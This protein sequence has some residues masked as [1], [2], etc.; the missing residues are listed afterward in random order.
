MPADPDDLALRLDDEP[1]GPLGSAVLHPGAA[2]AG[3]RWPPGRY[4]AVARALAR[5]GR[6]VRVSAGP[7]EESLAGEVIARA[8]LPP[9][10]LFAGR[11]LRALA[12]LVKGAALVVCGDTGL[13]H[14]ATA[15]GTSSVLLFGPTPPALWGPPPNRPWHRVLHRGG[16]GD[17]HA[18]RLDPALAAISVDDVLRE[19]ELLERL[20]AGRGAQAPAG[21]SA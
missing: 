6:P 21:A 4:A 18:A 11:D 10:A 5:R 15:L 14:L 13:G 17:P 1:E 3:R 20:L 19:I 8:G 2:V 7:G 12:R 16:R 9:H